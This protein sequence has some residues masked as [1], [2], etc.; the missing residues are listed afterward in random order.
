M[1]CDKM[2]QPLCVF[3]FKSTCLPSLR[4]WE[5]EPLSSLVADCWE[6]G[7]PSCRLG[8]SIF[9][10]RRSLMRGR[11]T[12]PSWALHR[13][14]TM[15]RGQPLSRDRTTPA[16]EK[17]KVF[18]FFFHILISVIYFCIVQNKYLTNKCCVLMFPMWTRGTLHTHT[19]VFSIFGS[20]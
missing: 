8:F 16:L 18:V 2:F 3:F 20:Q 7:G 17:G 10:A 5:E 15:D 11:Y 6:V 14:T 19:G 9:R 12:V 13:K 1:S 4:H